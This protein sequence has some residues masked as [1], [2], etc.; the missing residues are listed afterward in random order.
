MIF[1]TPFLE[2]LL[3][4]LQRLLLEIKYIAT[5]LPAENL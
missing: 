2:V 3:A 4:V 5:S 1:C